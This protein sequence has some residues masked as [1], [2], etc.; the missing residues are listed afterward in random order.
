MNI[1]VL[2]YNISWESMTGKKDWHLCN[3]T[4]P[5][6]DKYYGICR[7]NVV[8]VFDSDNYDFILL[9]EA[10]NYLDLINES[11]ILKTMKY[12]HHKSGKEDMVTFWDSKKY[13]LI[14]QIT[15][16]FEKGRP[17]QILR[18]AE[19][20]SVF[21]LHAPHLKR[22]ELI[23]AIN[24]ILFK[25][26]KL[27]VYRV[28]IGGDFNYFLNKKK[29]EPK[30]S[31]KLDNKIYYMSENIVPSCCNRYKNFN[32]QIDYI[33]DGNRPIK[34]YSPETHYLA[35]D[36]KPIVAIL[37]PLFQNTELYKSIKHLIGGKY[38]HKYL[39]YKSKYLLNK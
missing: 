20:V 6:D 2:T 30:N 16:Q 11:K 4:N 29:S 34:V 9:Q 28:I 14:E 15:G 31:I 38:Y 22:N 39:K 21:N 37:R 5:K 8:N 18:F 10:S 3:S 19:E 12:A 7:T 36:H 25:Y 35:S 32:K 23:S 17:W 24:K 33:L 13:N 1:K 26:P 27:T